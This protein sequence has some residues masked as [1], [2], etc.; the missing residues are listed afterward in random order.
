VSGWRLDSAGA[1]QCSIVGL[2][3]TV[4]NLGI[5]KKAGHFLIG[6]VTITF[7]NS[8]LATVIV[9]FVFNGND[10]GAS[11]H[12]LSYVT[13]PFAW[14]DWGKP[15]QIVSLAGL[16]IASKTQD[17]LNTKQ[18]VLTFRQRGSIINKQ[19]KRDKKERKKLGR[20]DGSK[21]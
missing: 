7:L 2:V 21:K 3:D 17:F 11:G 8:L 9:F 1:G 19:G 10:A 20:K 12:G 6:W 14:K 16:P 18:G 15:W 4:T 13:I 5:Y